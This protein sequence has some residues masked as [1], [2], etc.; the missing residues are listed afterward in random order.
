MASRKSPH[1]QRLLIKHERESRIA[2]ELATHVRELRLRNQLGQAEL[3]E[4]AG[5]GR[6]FI[7][8][9]EGG[10]PTLRLDAI[11]SV[12]TVFGKTLRIGDAPRD[13]GGDHDR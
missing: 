5:V 11:E 3:A 8:D 2:V 6:R 9:L 13:E 1:P 12:L 4:L 7:S 10:K